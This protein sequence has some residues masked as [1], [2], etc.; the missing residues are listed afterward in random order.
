[1]SRKRPSKNKPHSQPK[2]VRPKAASTVINWRARLRTMLAP[3][4]AVLAIVLLFSYAL[5]QQSV[6][7]AQNA[8]SHD[9]FDQAQTQLDRAERFFPLISRA[10]LEQHVVD[11]RQSHQTYLVGLSLFKDNRLDEANI[12]FSHVLATDTNYLNAQEYLK[13][14]QTQVDQKKHDQEQQRLALENALTQLNGSHFENALALL[15]TIPPSSIYSVDA[16]KLRTTIL[17]RQRSVEVPLLVQVAA[18]QLEAPQVHIPI[19]MYHYIST[20]PNALDKVRRD[21]SVDPSVFEE[22]M[23]YIATHNFT[24]ITLDQAYAGIE[25]KGTLPAKPLVLTFD[26]GYRDFYDTALPILQKYHLKAAVYVVASFA[27]NPAY[28]SW[29]VLDTVVASGLVE[30]GSHTLTH[31]DLPYK[32]DAQVFDEVVLSK[33][34]L[35]EHFHR[36]ITS[37]CYPYGGYSDKIVQ[38]VRQAGYKGATTT[39]AGSWHGKNSLLLLSRVRIKNAPMSSYLSQ[40]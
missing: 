22:Q 29:D 18:P 2:K 9:Q 21:L 27:S 4:A 34:I 3:A 39:V 19:L 32:S 28:M 24:T 5:S 38:V 31:A 16:A 26:D 36:A 37:F 20:P 12:S 10:A 14:I 1:M 11:L 40:F 13:T 35:E 17:L 33:R 25:G 8:L 15:Q 23:H 7:F 30:I 6:S